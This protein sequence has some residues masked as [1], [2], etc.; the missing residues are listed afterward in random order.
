MLAE[1]SCCTLKACGGVTIA[2]VM[3]VRVGPCLSEGAD[4]GKAVQG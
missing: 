2:A 1:L 4:D 3:V